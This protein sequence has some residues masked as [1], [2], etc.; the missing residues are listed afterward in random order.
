VPLATS[1][2]D[3]TTQYDFG[4]IENPYVEQF[5]ALSYGAS[6]PKLES[7]INT[8]ETR[9][10]R[11]RIEDHRRHRHRDYPPPKSNCEIT[12]GCATSQGQCS[13]SVKPTRPSTPAW[14]RSRL[15]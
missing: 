5:N 11:L 3:P 8:P 6:G 4:Q 12:A 15:T 10:G 7:Q 14:A 1:D 2:V 9:I 13:G